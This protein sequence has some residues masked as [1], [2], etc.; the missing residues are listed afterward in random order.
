[1][2]LT[3]SWAA[4]RMAGLEL[5]AET[6]LPAFRQFSLGSNANSIIIGF[7]YTD[8]CFFGEQW[9]KR[10]YYGVVIGSLGEHSTSAKIPWSYLFLPSVLFLVFITPWRFL[11]QLQPE[12][13]QSPGTF[14]EFLQGVRCRRL[15]LAFASFTGTLTG[16]ALFFGVSACVLTLLARWG[17]QVSLYHPNVLRMEVDL[18]ARG[19]ALDAICM[20]VKIDWSGFA[21]A[22]FQIVWS[23]GGIELERWR[24]MRAL[25]VDLRMALVVFF[26]LFATLL[27]TVRR[28]RIAERRS[29][30]GQCKACGYN[31]TGNVTGVCPEC[32]A[33]FR[34]T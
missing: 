10:A 13:T 1:M 23:W 21:S 32:G 25:R 27:M 34:P 6:M 9:T 17:F 19:S 7:G 3:A 30:G 15:W 29:L 12:E 16:F 31:L 4:A 2:M 14:R 20:A 18:G 24:Q 5:Q 28:H 8:L 33:G 11:R 22:P 26:V